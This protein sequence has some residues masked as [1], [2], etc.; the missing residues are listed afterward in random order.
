MHGSSRLWAPWCQCC[1]DAAA[2]A[3]EGLE[4]HTRCGPAW[5]YLA[6]HC[7]GAAYTHIDVLNGLLAYMILVPC[8][9]TRSPRCI[10]RLEE[11]NAELDT[12][13]RW[14]AFDPLKRHSVHATSDVFS[15]VLYSVERDIRLCDL[16][17]LRV[18]MGFPVGIVF[19]WRLRQAPALPRVPQRSLCTQVLVMV[20]TVIARSMV[21]QEILLDE[22]ALLLPPQ[23][24]RPVEISPTLPY[25][26]LTGGEICS[27]VVP[28]AVMLAIVPDTAADSVSPCL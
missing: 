20:Q 21:A 24:T 7:F 9:S 2:K 13:G 23:P 22:P 27:Q 25:D 12:M 5:S 10:L 18:V 19:P 11:A 8:G 4:C 15:L 16:P 3:S 26:P 1:C 14:Q 17:V 6:R 28:L